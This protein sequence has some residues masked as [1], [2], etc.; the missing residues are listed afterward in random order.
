MGVSVYWSLS[1][2]CVFVCVRSNERTS[3]KPRYMSERGLLGKKGWLFQGRGWGCIFYKKMKCNLK[4]ST[5][6]KVYKQKC[7]SVSIKNLNCRV[8]DEKLWGFTGK[9]N[10]QGKVHKKLIYRGEFH[11]KGGAWTFVDLRR[12]LVKKRGQCF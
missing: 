4:Y 12:G 11:K 5:T 7:F 10:F 2:L 3:K 9:S 1:V 6:K 8:K